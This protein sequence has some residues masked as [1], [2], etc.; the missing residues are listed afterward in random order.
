MPVYARYLCGYFSVSNYHLTF[1]ESNSTFPSTV[2]F[3]IQHGHIAPVSKNFKLFVQN[4][5]Y[6]ITREIPTETGGR[7]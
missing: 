6:R 7:G 4:D 2:V 1:L 5:V 3:Y